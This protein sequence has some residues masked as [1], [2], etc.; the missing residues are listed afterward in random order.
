MN[1][2]GAQRTTLPP[3]VS[4]LFRKYGS[5]DISKPYGPPRPVKGI[6]LPLV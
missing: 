2:P 4:R 6:T 5:L 1:L 3:Y